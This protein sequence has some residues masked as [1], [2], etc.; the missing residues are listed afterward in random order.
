MF[1]G[2]IMK[3]VCYENY[4]N[5][6]VLT[7]S[8]LIAPSYLECMGAHSLYIMNIGDNMGSWSL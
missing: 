3:N 8:R 1:L 4:N 6:T 5:E 2:E 7:V